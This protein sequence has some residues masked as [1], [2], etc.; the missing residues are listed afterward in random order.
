MLL[1]LSEVLDIP[2]RERNALFEA[3]GYAAIYRETP[4]DAP[5]MAQVDRVIGHILRA[6][7][8]TPAVV[9]NRRYDV[10][11]SN[12]AASAVM[13]GRPAKPGVPALQPNLLRLLLS[14]DCLRPTILNWEDVAANLVH[15]VR[16]EALT[17]ESL[18]NDLLPLLDE[19]L[20]GSPAPS[21]PIIDLTQPAGLVLPIR[22]QAGPHVL[23][24]LSTIT[25]LGTPLDVTLQ[26]LQIEAFH[27]ADRESEEILAHLVQGG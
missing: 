8:I 26:E 23:S 11:R 10:L 13:A 20:G 25:T 15:R 18:R 1:L 24:L 3:A 17:S 7:T 9:V 22:F 27:P 12:A 16:K 6:H 4:L 2:L 14:P 19:L 5:Q 21:F